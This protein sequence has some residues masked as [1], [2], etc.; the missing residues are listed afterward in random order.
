MMCVCSSVECQT[1]D[2]KS[3]GLNSSKLR[4][5][6]N[7]VIVSLRA[8]LSPMSPHGTGAETHGSVS[9][10]GKGRC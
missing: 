5:V 2:S 10:V 3:G 8:V 1:E 7:L 4:L 9:Q 6:L